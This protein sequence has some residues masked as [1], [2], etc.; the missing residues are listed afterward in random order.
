MFLFRFAAAV[1]ILCSQYTTHSIEQLPDR[2][3]SCVGDLAIYKSNTQRQVDRLLTDDF[4]EHSQNLLDAFNNTGKDVVRRYK[5]G[6]S[7]DVFDDLIMQEK[8]EF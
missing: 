2:I 5:R 6:I 1:L 3:S 7:A 4:N 8:R